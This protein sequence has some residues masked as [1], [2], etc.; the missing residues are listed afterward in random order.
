MLW[1]R[2][3]LVMIRILLSR[4]FRIR[5]L[6]L[7]LEHLSIEVYKRA[8][9]RP[10]FEICKGNPYRYAPYVVIN[11]GFGLGS[12]AVTVIPDLTR[13]KSSYS[14]STTLSTSI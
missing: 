14:E 8:T 1:I 2:I 7:E 13:P 4:S 3:D 11:V 9:E 5:I 6:E 10:F 12:G